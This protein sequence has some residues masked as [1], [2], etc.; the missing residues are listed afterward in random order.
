VRPLVVL[1]LLTAGCAA[2][3]PPPDENA[4][5]GEIVETTAEALHA[6]AAARGGYLARAQQ[7]YA[8]EPD[9]ANGLR[10][11][12]LLTVLPAPLRD[13]ERA[14]L[15]LRPVAG[16]GPGR[17]LSA[18]AR[19]LV[20]RIQESKGMAQDHAEE[21]RRERALREASQAREQALQRRTQALGATLRRQSEALRASEQREE[22]LKRQIEGMRASD[23]DLLERE[24]RIDATTK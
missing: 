11:A 8:A 20:E 18:F 24:E 23:R 5:V 16:R 17:P 12:L 4:V 15:L 6:P 21:L 2:L 19:L 14:L 13:E 9:D 7:A 22:T 1:L 10:V 3:R